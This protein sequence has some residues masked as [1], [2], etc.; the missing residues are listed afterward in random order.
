MSTA[1]TMPK[2]SKSKVSTIS[3]S[4]SALPWWYGDPHRGA[5]PHST[6]R[7]PGGLLREQVW[8]L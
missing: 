6:L 5:P 7:E 3:A 4:Q 1:F 8:R 2:V